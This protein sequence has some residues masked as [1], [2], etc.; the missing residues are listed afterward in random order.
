MT[1]CSHLID[2]EFHVLKRFQQFRL[3]HFPLCVMPQRLWPHVWNTL[4]PIKVTWAPGC[5]DCKLRQDWVDIGEG[6]GRKLPFFSDGSPTT[7]TRRSKR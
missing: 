6:Y 3:F 2:R 1:E 5:A 4:D 7:S